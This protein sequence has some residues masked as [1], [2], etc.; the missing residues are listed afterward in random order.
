MLLG[1]PVSLLRQQVF[2]PD[3]SIVD[4][5]LVDHKNGTYEFV[6]VIPKEGDFSLALR[7]YDQH[8]KGSPFKLSVSRPSEVEVR[9]AIP[10]KGTSPN[11]PAPLASALQVSPSATTTTNSAA[12]ATP[13]TGS[14][15]GAK[16]RGKSPGQKKKGSKRAS[17]ALGT[18][19]RKTQNPIEDDLIFKIG[20]R[21]WWCL[22]AAPGGGEPFRDRKWCN[23]W[24]CGL[25]D[26]QE[27]RAGTKGSS[28]TFR[29]WPRPPAAGS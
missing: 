3:G 8:I 19:R 2:T 1:R 20:E 4:G 29:A 25:A 15:E 10:R 5:E 23:W 14:S 27:P 26:P 12:Y 18:P 13:S 6:Y 24:L 22:I 9:P 17:S 21:S 16:R 11:T 7:L 28:P